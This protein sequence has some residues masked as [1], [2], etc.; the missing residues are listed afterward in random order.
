MLL[1]YGKLLNDF[2]NI[3]LN[4]FI[5]NKIRY[6]LKGIQNV[7]ASKIIL[8][9]YSKQYIIKYVVNNIIRKANQLKHKNFIAEIRIDLDEELFLINCGKGN[10]NLVHRNSIIVE[11]FDDNIIQYT[12][13]S[14]RLKN[15]NND[16]IVN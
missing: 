15:T 16:S 14:S 7:S 2:H 9:C 8:N 3:R 10:Y 13:T 11:H 12:Q 1:L 5:K 6:K 4:F